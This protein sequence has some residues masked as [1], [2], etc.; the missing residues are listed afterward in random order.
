MYPA[1][2]RSSCKRSTFSTSAHSIASS[3]RRN[4]WTPSSSMP[5]GS[6]DRGPH[7]ATSAPS[8]SR[9]QMLL[10]ATRLCIMS[11][12]MHTLQ[13]A[14]VPRL[15]R[16]DSRS[17]SP[18]VGCSCQ[19]SPALMTFEGIRSARNL[20][21]PEAGCRTTTMSIRIASRLRAVSTR[22]SP[23]SIE[24]PDAAM[25]TVSADRRFSA[26]SKEMRVRVDDS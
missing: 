16:I 25:F 6:S 4:T 24:D 13:P 18:W 7:T 10:R 8:L 21:A 20:G 1:I 11:P 22:L 26:N 14:S 23:F 3:G 2:I 12:Q 5:R 15:S 9:P 17:S 19:P